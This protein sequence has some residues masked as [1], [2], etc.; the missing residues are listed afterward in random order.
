MVS[1]VVSLVLI[2]TYLLYKLQSGLDTEVESK[3]EAKEH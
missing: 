3:S 2:I 1:L